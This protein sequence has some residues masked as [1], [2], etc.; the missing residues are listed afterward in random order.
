MRTTAFGLECVAFGVEF[1]L[2]AESDEMLAKMRLC[3]PFGAEAVME[4]H[5]EPIEF[6]IYQNRAGARYR[7]R[8]KNEVV[9]ESVERHDILEQLAR[10]LMV[11]VANCA[12]DRVFVHAGVVRW[13]DGVVLLPGMSFAGKTTLVAALVRCSATYYSDEYAVIDERGEVHPYARELQMREPGGV[14]QRGIRVTTL[15]GVAA[16]APGRVS[17]VVFA[18]YVQGGRWKP[19]AMSHGEAVLE[20]MRHAI[21]VQRAP[22][23]VMASLAKMMETAEAMRTARGEANETAR[24]LLAMMP[25]NGGEV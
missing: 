19:E 13:K 15:G 16:S 23:R 12:P 25:A 9:G 17:H 20:M 8:I 21:A 24:Q 11:H 5:S 22:A 18:D 10:E 6:A 7:L 2:A 4:A 1:R 14:E 3:A